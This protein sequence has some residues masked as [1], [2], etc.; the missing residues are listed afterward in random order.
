MFT[1]AIPD[2]RNNKGFDTMDQNSDV[3]YR[4]FL[5]AKEE[6]R[7]LKISEVPEWIRLVPYGSTELRLT[8]FPDCFHVQQNGTLK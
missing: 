7:D 3:R 5:P 2:F 8:V 4:D 6:V 1:P